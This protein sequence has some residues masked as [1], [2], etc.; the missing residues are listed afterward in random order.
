MNSLSQ[1]LSGDNDAL[2]R[3]AAAKLMTEQQLLSLNAQKAQLEKMAYATPEENAMNSAAAAKNEELGQLNH[4]IRQNEAQLAVLR[5]TYTT[6]HPDLIDFEEK[7]E[8][9]RQRRDQ[10]VKDDAIAA[11]ATA[12]AEAKSPRLPQSRRASS[13]RI[14]RVCNRSRPPLTRLRHS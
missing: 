8:V 11:A 7:L 6:K 1:Q 4:E 3:N 12:A 2:S 5:K 9:L 10:M 14:S 13:F